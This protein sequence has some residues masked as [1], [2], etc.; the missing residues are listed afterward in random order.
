MR[1]NTPWLLVNF[2]LMP[3]HM[4]IVDHWYL[5]VFD[6]HQR[7]LKLFNSPVGKTDRR[8]KKFLEPFVILLPLLL[9]NMGFY[10]N[11]IDVNKNTS[12]FIG[13]KDGDQFDTL[14]VPKLPKQVEW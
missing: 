5:L 7:R 12:Y 8:L 4:D 14:V 6:I 3:V 2:V 1:C 10:Q 13:K 9:A 11:R